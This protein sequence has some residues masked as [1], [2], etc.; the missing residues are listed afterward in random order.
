[1]GQTWV[2]FK[3]DKLFLTRYFMGHALA[4]LAIS[5]LLGWSS[6]TNIELKLEWAHLLLFPVWI[7]AGIQ[8]PVLMHNCMHSN[9]L[10]RPINDVLGE[11]SA[12]FAL[13]SLR[14]LQINHTLHHAHSDTAQDPHSPS[15]KSFVAFF[16][17]AQLTGANIIAEKFF[18]FHGRTKSHIWLFRGNTAL[19]YTSHLL[20]L[21]V[22]FQLLGPTLFVAAYLPS[23]LVYSIVFAHVNYITHQ[24]SDSGEVEILNKDDNLYYNFI[25]FIGS[26]V[27]YHKNHH[28]HPKL[29]NP[30]FVKIELT[31]PDRL[32]EKVSA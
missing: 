4:L 15:N 30:K 23:F 24:T 26:G 29:M 9:V 12:F 18:S 17:S 27:Y 5:W 21:A 7:L 6:F 25:N 10:S 31:I 3:R 19:H 22:W 16:F 32:N 11:L 28:D 20:R 8:I 1:M 13:M 14:I 2:R